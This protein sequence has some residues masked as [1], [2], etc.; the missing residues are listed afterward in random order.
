MLGFLSS[1]LKILLFSI[2]QG[3]QLPQ[4][5]PE[6]LMPTYK[7]ELHIPGMT[8]REHRAYRRLFQNIDDRGT[9]KLDGKLRKFNR[10]Q[11]L[12]IQGWRKI[13]NYFSS[14]DGPLKCL[15][16]F[17]NSQKFLNKLKLLNYLRPR[18]QHFLTLAYS[19]KTSIS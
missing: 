7:E 4:H 17:T 3:K 16:S 18:S 19:N 1:Y 6:P 13:R 12:M 9:G 11:P 8:S 2:R 5:L 15:N 10:G 14:H